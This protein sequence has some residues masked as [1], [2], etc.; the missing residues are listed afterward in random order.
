MAPNAT[1]GEQAY[2]EH[3]ISQT[4]LSSVAHNI[5]KYTATWNYRKSNEFAKLPKTSQSRNWVVENDHRKTFTPIY[6]YIQ[7]NDPRVA[8]YKLNI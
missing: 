5:W 4:R 2:T 3:Q 8:L 7:K 6:I 1:H